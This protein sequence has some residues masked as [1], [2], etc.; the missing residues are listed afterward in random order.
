MIAL[1]SRFFHYLRH[2]WIKVPKDADEE[3]Y[4]RLSGRRGG[5][6]NFTLVK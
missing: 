3:K 4:S 6:H 1:Y 2:F 5:E